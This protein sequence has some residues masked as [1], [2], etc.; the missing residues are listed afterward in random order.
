MQREPESQHA[1]HPEFFGEIRRTESLE[2]VQNQVRSRLPARRSDVCH[3]P[4]LEIAQLRD[5]G[6]QGYQGFPGATRIA[7]DDL[8]LR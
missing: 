2:M 7:E 4:L 5:H 1:W 8:P 3:L 6:R